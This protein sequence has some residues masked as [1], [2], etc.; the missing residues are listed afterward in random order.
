MTSQAV[1]DD[2]RAAWATKMPECPY[3][4]STN[5]SPNNSSPLPNLWATFI[6]ESSRERIS[7]GAP[8]ACYRETGSIAVVIMT[9][10]G[11]GDS[12]AGTTAQQVVDRFVGYSGAG[13]YFLV[14][15]IQPPQDGA[16]DKPPKSEYYQTVVEMD[17]Q[18]ESYQ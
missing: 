15:D 2:I 4:D 17:Y 10:A 9:R 1:R 12:L 18:F 14:T 13:G 7:I 8:L 11:T 16:N 3:Y 6:F 5:R